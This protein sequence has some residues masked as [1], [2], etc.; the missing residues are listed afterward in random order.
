M[1]EREHE[2]AAVES[3][4][5]PARRRKRRRRRRVTVAS[6]VALLVFVG[7]VAVLRSERF[8]HW[9]AS[10]LAAQVRAE[11]GLDVTLGAVGFSFRHLA[12]RIDRVSVRRPEEGC[13]PLVTV[14]TVEVVPAVGPLL[15]RRVQLA[16]LDVTGGSVDLR[17][18]R[19]AHGVVLSCGPVSSGR[20]SH[21]K[22]GELPFRD[23]SV[24]DVRVRVLHPEV[25]MVELGSVDFDAVNLGARRVRAGVLGLHGHAQTQ[26][27]TGALRRVEA[28]ATVDLNRGNVRVVPAVIEAGR[29]SVRVREAE[30]VAGERA[31]V[32]ASVRAYLEDV[33]RAIPGAPELEGLA[34]VDLRVSVRELSRVRETLA[35]EGAVTGLGLGLW[36][37]D[38][39]TR[40]RIRFNISDRAS[41]RFTADGNG[42][43]V[44]D[45]EASY[46]HGLLRSREVVISLGSTPAINGR[47]TLDGLDFTQLM[48]DVTVTPRTKI[49]WTISGPLQLH[50]TLDPLRLTVDLR[51]MEGR[52][53][54]LLQDY[55]TVLPQRAVVAIARSRVSCRMEIDPAE[56]A[57]ND[58]DARFGNSR[59]TLRQ[60]R[61]RTSHDATHRE[62]DLK[63]TGL[64]IERLD[65][66]DVG[67][68]AGLEVD[69]H[70]TGTV[71]A[72]TDT[73]VPVLHGTGRVT[74]FRVTGLPFGELD[75]PGWTLRGERVEIAEARGRTRLERAGYTL[76]DGFMD[77]SRW[78]VH[79]G[80]RVGAER[81]SLDDFYDMFRFTGDP[82]LTPYSGVGR[83]EA[84]VDYV[85]GRPGDDRDGV[86][87]VSARVSDADVVAFGERL[88]DVDVKLG[89]E[90]LRRR[91]GIRG[92]RVDLQEFTGRKGTG[93]VRVSG[94]M[95]LG[96]RMHFAAVGT[97]VPLG[98][99]DLLR[100]RNVSGEL[101][102]SVTVE[103]TPDAP[104]AVVESDVRELTV[105][106][107]PLGRT[108][109]RLTQLP[110]WE[111]TRELREGEHPPGNLF[112]LSVGALDDRLRVN[113]TLA[114]PWDDS[115]WRD[116]GGVEHRTVARAWGRSVL[117]GDVTATEALDLLPWLTP[118]ILAR[119]GDDPEARAQFAVHVDR[120][121][122]NQ[123]NRVEGSAELSAL[124][125]RARGVPFSLSSGGRVGVCLRN[126]TAWVTAT[127]AQ[128]CRENHE[129]EI[130]AR[131]RRFDRS[132]P[133]FVG[134]DGAR[135]WVGGGVE[136][137]EDLSV[138]SL[139]VSARAEADLA[140]LAARAPTVSWARG[141]AV[142]D[143][144]AVGDLQHPNLSGSV[145]LEDAA[146]TA[147]GLPAPLTDVDL[148]VRVQGT[149]AVIQRA[150]ARVGA[151]TV[152]LTRPG[153]PGRVSFDGTRF[154]RL[155]VPVVVRGLSLSPMAGA[156][157]G[158]DVDAT[159]RWSAG[160][161]LPMVQGDVKI[162]RA[163]YTRPVPLSADLAGRLQGGGQSAPAAPYDPA[164][165]LL[166]LDLT[167][168]T[169][170]P[171]RMVN[172][173]GDVEFSLS[174]SPPFRVQGTQQ[175]PGVTGTMTVGRGVVRLYENEF[176]VRRG[177][178][179][180]DSPDRIS[181]G[182]DVEAETEVRR[183]GDSSRSQWRVRARVAG[184]PDQFA[185]E[186]SSE[187]LLSR[188]DIV[189]LLLFRMTRTELDRLGGLNTG[190]TLAIEVLS[191][192]LGLDRVVRSA[193]PVIDDF[194][195][196]SA[197]N[198]RTNR[199]EPQ[200]SVGRQ[201][202]EWLRIGG[203]FTLSEQPLA[204]A[205]GDIR[206]GDQLGIQVLL[207][208]ANNQLGT[209]GANVGADLRW[210]MEFH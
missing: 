41:L 169:P 2:P 99:M 4:S 151:G 189:L 131:E 140:R 109:V 198:P 188:A 84:G 168:H 148:E 101:S 102:A 125:L 55:F 180:F 143:I 164:N 159:V 63:I 65:L 31:H 50:G 43:R 106:G 194:R 89:Y 112:T 11:T 1:A 205:T 155:D 145:V 62:R 92:A 199:T 178:V 48:H 7:V 174:E 73:D 132:R 49:L 116:V 51:E 187:P 12:V 52:N 135:L 181:A 167:V 20:G 172:N 138:A 130:P 120:A 197:Y 142:M 83:V 19:G 24:S 6:V 184:T 71:S 56:I 45:L 88:E 191:L 210:R 175:R 170:T 37:R 136:L 152:S 35:A 72:D 28:R 190:Q 208:S 141:T 3:L 40:E 103:G 58:C 154:E 53:F 13:V 193:I 160:E 96:G 22:P 186:L 158:V 129:G 207:E 76:R 18:V 206:L 209:Q 98:A 80:G 77:F 66:R 137:A 42:V 68:I 70:V 108:R 196:G 82:V 123:L 113:G 118:G 33:I 30:F 166:R 149:E 34:G 27:F 192:T 162:T 182:F 10:E 185:I 97:D 61:I 75:V 134:P 90:W 203:A 173:L 16:R 144:S 163:R 127:G 111:P 133:T 87:T 21:S 153:R 79:V 93:R 9:V 69:G 25:G 139:D 29:T 105:L 67:A 165:D 44:T 57:W 15:E 14:D 176:D 204:R 179:T 201:L 81:L 54:A 100:G 110:E 47:F 95:D 124:S 32:D 86:M 202:L 117:Q 150:F 171:M 128:G 121:Q 157:V 59:A 60:I 161:D 23:I 177:R 200:V 74:E 26:W 195:V 146:V 8:T 107:R 104:R 85:L 46:A 115:R 94:W 39:T 147:A 17:F 36:G 114:V 38:S 122:L 78:T 119:L 183:T 156:D 5:P 91:D 126:G 64:N